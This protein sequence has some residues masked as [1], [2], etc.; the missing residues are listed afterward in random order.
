MIRPDNA[1]IVMTVKTIVRA[2]IQVNEE[3]QN[4]TPIT[5][6]PLNK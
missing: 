6:K 2:T 5:P 4:S 3:A 1:E